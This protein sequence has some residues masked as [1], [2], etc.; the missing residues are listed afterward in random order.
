MQKRLCTAPAPISRH[1]YD[2]RRPILRPI[3]ELIPH[4]GGIG[5]PFPE[6]HNSEAT[7]GQC[8]P[9]GCFYAANRGHKEDP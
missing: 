1:K 2:H 4:A 7:N 8:E 9:V 5:R 3:F 6:S